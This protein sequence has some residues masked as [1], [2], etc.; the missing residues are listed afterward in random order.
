MSARLFAFLGA[1]A[2]LVPCVGSGCG[3]PTTTSVAPEAGARDAS[4][5]LVHV[6]TSG[7]GANTSSGGTDPFAGLDAPTMDEGV[8]ET[9]SAPDDGSMDD[10]PSSSGS[11][12]MMDSGSDAAPN[13]CDSYT[14]PLCGT[15]PC[16]LRSNTC[17]VLFTLQ[18]PPPARCVPGAA[19]VCDKS[20]EVTVHCLH[21]CDCQ[22]ENCCGLY[23][24]IHG[25]VQS[26][27]Q[28]DSELVGGNCFPSPPTAV[29]TSAQLCKVD[30]E[31]QNGQPCID[32]T[33]I[34]GA[35]LSICGLQSQDPFKCMATG[36]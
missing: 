2:A 22:G 5:V 17:C 15:V 19:A 31:C 27:C 6:V 7:G 20:K 24:K 16:D 21:A 13:A 11:G 30:S 33:C 32:Q 9:G 1:L 35:H 3:G 29:V 4:L 26:V 34:Y 23:D 10:G 14:P 8:P 25:V 18:N 28:P 36:D 12:G